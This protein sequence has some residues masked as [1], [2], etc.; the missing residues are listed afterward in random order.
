[1]RTASTLG[2]T[3]LD[4]NQNLYVSESGLGEL[5]GDF[6]GSLMFHR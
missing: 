1:M 4:K 5:R 3:S 6:K 2:T